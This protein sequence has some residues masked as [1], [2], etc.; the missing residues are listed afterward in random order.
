MQQQQRP[1]QW[2]QQQQ[3]TGKGNEKTARNGAA[4]TWRERGSGI[5][6]PFP[7][8]TRVA[9]HASPSF[10]HH[11]TH[12]G[13]HHA[14]RPIQRCLLPGRVVQED[15]DD[16]VAGPLVGGTVVVCVG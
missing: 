1:Q 10:P 15:G 5:V 14:R 9:A 12:T 8:L 7:R 16:V 11:H 2:Q 4:S 3:R 6:H 13:V